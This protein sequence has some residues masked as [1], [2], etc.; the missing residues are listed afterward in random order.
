MKSR[1]F[2]IFL[3]ARRNY[4]KKNTIRQFRMVFSLSLRVPSSSLLFRFRLASR[5]AEV[6]VVSHAPA[7]VGI[8]IPANSARRERFLRIRNFIEQRIVFPLRGG[9]IVCRELPLQYRI[10][11]L[12]ELDALLLLH[13]HIV[14]RIA[15][16]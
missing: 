15:M 5:L 16:D 14:L 3:D 2:C 9:L 1:S 7:N 13:F 6:M 10:R 8:E 4:P 12:V 11:R